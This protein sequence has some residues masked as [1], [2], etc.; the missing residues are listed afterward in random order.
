MLSDVGREGVMGAVCIGLE[1]AGGESTER[2]WTLEEKK[3]AKT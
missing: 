2:I 3:N 1:A